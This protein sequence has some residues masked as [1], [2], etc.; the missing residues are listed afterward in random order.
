MNYLFWN[1]STVYVQRIYRRLCPLGMVTEY[2]TVKKVENGHALRI[3]YMKTNLS[4]K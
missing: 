1:I 4:Q 2:D 3:F